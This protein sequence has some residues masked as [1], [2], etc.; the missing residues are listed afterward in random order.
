MDTIDKLNL[1]RSI[2]SPVEQI[3]LTELRK[4]IEAGLILTDKHP[5][6]D[7]YIYNYT[8]RTQYERM[9]D[10]Y[11]R[12]CRGLILNSS[13]NIVSR[14]FPKFFNLNE[15]PETLAQNLPNEIPKIT[16]TDTSEARNKPP[17]DREQRIG[18]T[19]RAFFMGVQT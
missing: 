2:K 7:L 16:I 12:I 4:R 14:P 9:W 1:I 5:E 6:L 8:K 15:T 19:V 3:D 17:Q 10:R 18:E 13:G 11:T